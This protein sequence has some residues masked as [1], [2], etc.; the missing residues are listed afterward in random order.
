MEKSEEGEVK[1]EESL[2]PCEVSAVWTG[3]PQEPG[4][5][6]SSAFNHPLAACE[7]SSITK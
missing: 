7:L 4:A 3:P 6:R 2:L 1:V 5:R